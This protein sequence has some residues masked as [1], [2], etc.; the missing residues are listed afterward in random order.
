MNKK[1]YRLVNPHIEGTFNPLVKAKNPPSAAKHIYQKLAETFTNSVHNFNFAIQNIETKDITHF[2]IKEKVKKGGSTVN[3]E[4]SKIPPEIIPDGIND[5]LVKKIDEIE[6][7]QYGGNKSS[8]YDDDTE[9]IT[10]SST[11]SD[12]L[13][14]DMYLQPITK[15]T[16]FYIPYIITT[17]IKLIGLNMNDYNDLFT[18][19]FSYPIRPIIHIRTDFIKKLI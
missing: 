19:S 12:Y 13:N 17:P 2:N 10:D 9:T 14:D 3:Y 1:T 11:E 16:Y 6:S 8:K 18:P 7:G 15:F 5:K 4:L